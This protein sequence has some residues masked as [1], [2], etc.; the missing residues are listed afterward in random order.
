MYY[1]SRHP[2]HRLTWK[3]NINEI[4]GG[5]GGAGQWLCMGRDYNKL[6]GLEAG[7]PRNFCMYGNY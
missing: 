6:G 7:L 2:T 5:R 4:M 3:I 1:S